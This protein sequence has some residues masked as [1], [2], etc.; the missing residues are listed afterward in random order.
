M[1]TLTHPVQLVP[2]E[3]HAGNTPDHHTYTSTGGKPVYATYDLPTTSISWA[4]AMVNLKTSLTD[5]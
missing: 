4:A 2:G 3:D 5:P 1:L